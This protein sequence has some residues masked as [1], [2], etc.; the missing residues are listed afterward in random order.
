MR[1]CV[2]AL[3]L[4]ALAASAEACSG[5]TTGGIKTGK[6][7]TLIKDVP[8]T[9]Q[10]DQMFAQPDGGG[11]GS[12]D[13]YAYSPLTVC[14]NCACE[15]GTYCFGGGTGHTT[16]SGSCTNAGSLDVGCQPLPSSCA[17]TPTCA[18][19]LS[20]LTTSKALS[21]YAVCSKGPTVYCPSP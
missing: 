17:S 7:D 5:D 20:A 3:G 14:K 16:F 18:C 4:A 9:T 6:G 21:C 10:P 2:V 11:Y 8:P 12:P 15:A 13:A 19:V 1:L